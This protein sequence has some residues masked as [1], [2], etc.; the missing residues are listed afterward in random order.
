MEV[1][2]NKSAMPKYY[3]AHPI[4]DRR[5]IRAWETEIEKRFKIELINPFYDA[6]EIGNTPALDRGEV[7]LYDP[8]FDSNEIVEGDL[9]LI[10][11]ADGVIALVTGS[12]SIG[13]YMEIFFNSYV[14]RRPTQIIIEHPELVAHSWLRHM[15]DVSYG[16][17]YKSREEFVKDFLE[18]PNKPKRN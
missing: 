10:R 17:I 4:R 11:K 6:S 18:K 1:K 15:S 7:N 5:D 3:L 14:L 16:H 8:S 13:T 9:D 2:S 12:M